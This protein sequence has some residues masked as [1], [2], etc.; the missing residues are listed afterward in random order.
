M[1][2]TDE[3]EWGLLAGLCDAGRG[4]LGKKW[5]I[6]ASLSKLAT[7]VVKFNPAR[8]ASVKITTGE[9][10]PGPDDDANPHFFL[11]LFLSI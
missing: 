10:A 6:R 5:G 8:I 3:F 1:P 7:L 11:L 9:V 2:V 4:L